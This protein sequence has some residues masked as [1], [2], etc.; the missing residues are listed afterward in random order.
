MFLSTL[1]DNDRSRGKLS[2]EYARCCTD[3]K[4][5]RSVYAR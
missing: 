4:Q 3:V 5:N 2:V 1:S